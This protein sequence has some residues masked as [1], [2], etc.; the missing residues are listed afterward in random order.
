MSAASHEA[1]RAVLNQKK[2]ELSAR[3]TKITANLRRGYEADS[4]ERAKQLEDNEVVDALGN[5][6]RMEIAKISAALKR[7]DNGEYGICTE[8][9]QAIEDGR[10]QAYPYADECIECAEFD[11]QRRMRLEGR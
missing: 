1:L 4:K 5:E 3:L 11:E 6:A 7:M 8:C 2:E 9:G 10:L